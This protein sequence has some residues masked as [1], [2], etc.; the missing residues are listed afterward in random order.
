MWDTSVRVPMLMR[1]PAVIK[2][3]RTI[4]DMVSHLDLFRT[5]LGAA[6][7]PVPAD[8]RAHG[9]DFSPLLRG[10][11]IA[12][13]NRVFGQYD[14]HN[15]NLAYMRMVRTERYKLV[16]FFHANNMDELYD[17]ER[18]PDEM[19]NLARGP[20]SAEFESIQQELRE[21]LAQWMKSI[22]DPLL[23]DRY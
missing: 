1:W 5:L 22:N 10:G 13:R 2:P 16:R 7:V 3:G 14:L 9:V 4:D 11:T 6:G 18:D 15:S 12:P 20:R 23:H 21:E 19:Q 8:A 17:L